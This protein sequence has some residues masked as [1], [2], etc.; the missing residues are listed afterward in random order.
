MKMTEEEARKLAS[1]LVGRSPLHGPTYGAI[2]DVIL[3]AC[4]A[5]SEASAAQLAEANSLLQ[6]LESDHIKQGIYIQSVESGRDIARGMLAPAPCGKP[7]HR[8]AEWVEAEGQSVDYKIRGK[9]VHVEMELGHCLACRD[10][11]QVA[12][13]A[14]ERAMEHGLCYDDEMCSCGWVPDENGRSDVAKLLEQ[15]KDHIRS[16]GPALAIDEIRREAADQK[17]ECGHFKSCLHIAPV[18]KSRHHTEMRCEACAAAEFREFQIKALPN[19]EPYKRFHATLDEI[20]REARDT[21]LVEAA[22]AICVNCSECGPPARYAGVWKHAR[23]MD[24]LCHCYARGIY[25]LRA[26]AKAKEVDR[27]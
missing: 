8:R 1:E 24:A 20:R 22:K 9:Q 19:S 14:V 12:V 6:G 11:E 7:G 10:R 4:A 23:G 25:D 5:E 18:Q 3:A 21:A 27:G 15:W 26:K 13:A 17:M 16:L 2:A